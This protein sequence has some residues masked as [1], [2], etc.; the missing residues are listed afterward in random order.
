MSQ[1][2][3]RVLRTP[4][5][6]LNML[7]YHISLSTPIEWEQFCMEGAISHDGGRSDNMALGEGKS[8][9]TMGESDS[10]PQHG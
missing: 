5:H 2:F 6:V 8:N 4:P 3:W 1:R 9:E 10:Q 7:I